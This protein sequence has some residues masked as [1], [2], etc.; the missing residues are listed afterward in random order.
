MDEDLV[1]DA[2][3]EDEY[4]ELLADL[5]DENIYT[6]LNTEDRATEAR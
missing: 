6:V 3:R 2:V 1:A 4:R 5:A